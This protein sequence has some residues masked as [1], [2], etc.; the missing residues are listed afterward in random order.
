MSDVE[1]ALSTLLTPEKIMD[2]LNVYME[3]GISAIDALVAFAEENDIEI[4]TVGEIVKKN[5]ALKAIVRS[6]AE[7]LRLVEKTTK[8]PI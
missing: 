1:K 5:V 7:N 4:Q 2:E 3:G 8:L 6:D